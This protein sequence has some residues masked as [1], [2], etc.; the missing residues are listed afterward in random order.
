MNPYDTS[1]YFAR[2]APRYQA[3]LAAF[4][5]ARILDFLPYAAAIRASGLDRKPRVRICDAFGGTGF[6]ARGLR[7]RSFDFLVCD[8]CQEMLIGATGLEKV[9][10]HVTPDDFRS[11]VAQYGEGYFDIVLSHGG[12]HHVVEA[13]NGTV[14]LP[15][16]E[17]RQQEVAERL[18][19]LVRPEG[20][21]IIA[22]IPREEPPE[23]HDRLGAEVLD[24]HFLS[25]LLGREAVQMIT[26]AVD[27][28]LSQ[29]LTFDAIRQRIETRLVQSVSTTVPRFFFDEF[30]AAKTAMGHVAAYPDFLA[31]D[32]V[33]RQTGLV[34]W[35]RVNYRG[36]WLFGSEAEAGWFFRE[37]FS[38]GQAAP[39]GE[40]IAS[41][42][43]MFRIVKG[44]LGVRGKGGLVAVNW[45][46]TY[47]VYQRGR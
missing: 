22:D 13:D 14:G 15:A 24:E 39:Q 34:S 46:V 11:T 10:L 6:L 35:G 28:D 44:L 16:S 42:Q 43:Y 25:K 36:P 37:K 31:L 21:L 45:G 27:A 41:E 12:L 38:V 18:A 47:A 33:L 7:S 32:V 26:R 9:E 4:P 23:V 20:L 8:C 3:A 17:N 5:M 30:V 19:H 1:S 40:D 29:P 2:R